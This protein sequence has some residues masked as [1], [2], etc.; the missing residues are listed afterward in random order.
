MSSSLL[1]PNT[2]VDKGKLLVIL[3][4]PQKDNP[5]PWHRLLLVDLV[6]AVGELAGVLEETH[7]LYAF[8]VEPDFDGVESSNVVG[9]PLHQ[10]N[11]VL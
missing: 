5:P 9:P 4:G 7:G 8:F 10:P 3:P 6:G 11:H 2:V 1:G